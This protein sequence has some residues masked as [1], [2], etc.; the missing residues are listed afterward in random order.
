MHGYRSWFLINYVLLKFQAD[1]NGQIG[2]SL[3]NMLLSEIEFSLSFDRDHSNITRDDLMN[4]SLNCPSR[5]GGA[6]SISTELVFSDSSGS[7]TASALV[8]RT[9]EWIDGVRTANGFSFQLIR[10]NTS[11]P[12]M[13]HAKSLYIHGMVFSTIW[14]CVWV[15]HHQAAIKL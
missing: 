3:L 10:T 6:F 15:T 12:V 7:V 9:Q 14:Q 13:L 4:P 2:N 1:V 5:R 8:E 11:I